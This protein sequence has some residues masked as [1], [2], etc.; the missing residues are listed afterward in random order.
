MTISLSDSGTLT[1]RLVD[2]DRKHVVHTALHVS[3]T[4]H[5]RWSSAMGVVS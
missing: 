5:V 3:T 4:V 1:D 2:L